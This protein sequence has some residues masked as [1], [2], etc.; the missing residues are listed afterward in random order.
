MRRKTYER[1]CRELAEYEDKCY[2]ELKEY[3]K[4]YNEKLNEIG[5][6]I[7]FRRLWS[8]FPISET[9]EKKRVPFA[10]GYSCE[11][12]ILFQNKGDDPDDETLDI[13]FQYTRTVTAYGRGLITLNLFHKHKLDDIYNY[14]DKYYNEI[15]KNGIEETQKQCEKNYGTKISFW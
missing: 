6:E 11:F 14:I 10:R 7:I 9:Y 5:C 8:I 3:I 13:G 2:R 12:S 1:K 4:P 15:I